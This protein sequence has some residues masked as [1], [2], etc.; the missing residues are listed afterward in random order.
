M[1]IHST[2]IKLAGTE[3]KYKLILD[4][5]PD[6]IAKVSEEGKFLYAN[7]AMAKSFGI[8]REKLIGKSFFDVM[9]EKL[10]E[11]RLQI[12]K[13]AI[14][15]G[16]PQIFED[17]RDDRYFHNVYFPIPG[18]RSF[19]VIARDIT[20][21]KR[22]EEI[23]RILVNGTAGGIYI[24]QD[25]RLIFV[26]KAMQDLSGYT[27]KELLSMNYLDLIHPD[28]RKKVEEMTNMALKGDISGIPSRF[29]FKAIRKDG[30]QVWIENLPT[31]VRYKGKN[32]IIGNIRDIT[33]QKEVG[34]E[35]IRSLEKYKTLVETIQEGFAVVDFDEKI[36]FA[37][38][39]ACKIS[40][41]SKDELMGMNLKQ[42]VPEEDFKRILEEIENRKRGKTSEYEVKIRRKDG[43]IIDLALLATPW[44]NKNGKI[45]GTIGLFQDITE[46][47]Q[48]EQ[49]IKKLFIMYRELGKAVSE[50]KNLKELS[51]KILTALNNIIN[52]DLANLLVYRPDDNSLV[53]SGQ[54][55]Y[56]KDLLKKTIKKQKVKEGSVGVASFC[57]IKKEP[58]YIENM[59]RHQLTKYA[60]D[61][62]EKYNLS[63]IYSVPLISKNKL[64]GVLQIVVRSGKDISPQD[65]ELINSLSEE[66]AAGIAKIRLEEELRELTRKDYLTDLYNYRYL[67]EKL[68]EQKMRSERYKEVYSVV[69]LDIDNFKCC[70]DTYGHP[71][72]DKILQIIGKILKKNLRKTDSAYRYGGDEFVIL[73][74]HTPKSQ[75]KNVAERISQ[76]IYLKLYKKYKIT[77]SIGITDSKNNEDVIGVADKAMYEAKRENKKI[78]V[79]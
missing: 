16:K 79:E 39:A 36:I 24:F 17:S 71:E 70:N 38:K 69:Y 62:C 75:A 3:E 73:L 9:P 57:A 21:K 77:V 7:F 47:K 59:K 20:E 25:G 67:Q 15:E 40:G 6:L 46:R 63:K 22:R 50:S 68:K 32:A 1:G 49:K 55:G 29:E 14:K 51:I 66:I 2:T 41:Y 33:E 5:S 37:N 61:L 23:Y 48:T 78:K 19:Q 54:I 44:R 43:K 53:I 42:L 10:A 64:E 27:E 45:V 26:N 31:L 12:G 8:E 76:E 11:K 56:P 4:S 58:L 35:L 13:K 34:E 60:L 52:Y 28:Y 72:G 18:E 65:R 74:P 30:K